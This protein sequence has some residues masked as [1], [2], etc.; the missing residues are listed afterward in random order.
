MTATT[1][2]LATVKIRAS[3]CLCSFGASLLCVYYTLQRTMV[4]TPSAVSA[5]GEGIGY[6]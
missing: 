6:E 3:S 5:S 2:Q 1:N 4:A